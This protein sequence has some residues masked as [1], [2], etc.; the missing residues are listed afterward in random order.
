MMKEVGV[1]LVVNDC[2]HETKYCIENLTSKTRYNIRLHIL[3]NGSED[4]RVTEYLKEISKDNKCFFIRVE[5][6]LPL[7][8]AYNMIIQY[9]YQEYCCIFPINILV[10]DLWCEELVSEYT[11]SENAGVISIRSGR[12]NVSLSTIMHKSENPEGRMKNVWFTSN[13]AVDGILFFAREHLEKTGM[14]D[15]RLN[16]EGYET[17]EFTFRFAA[18]GMNN[19]YIAK[20]TCS[21]VDIE[22]KYLFPKKTL[23]GAKIVKDEIEVMVK[24]KHFKK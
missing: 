16:A 6:P 10:N 20:H 3:D 8:E 9:S 14:F 4:A 23:E 18:H 12:E 19:Y 22:N 24:T 2:Y 11:D 1:C 13:N 17:A 21:K 7:G 5:K 15:I